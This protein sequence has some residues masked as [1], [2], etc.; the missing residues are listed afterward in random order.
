MDDLPKRPS[1]V[2]AGSDKKPRIYTIG[3][4]TLPF[5]PFVSLLKEFGI[6]LVADV[7]RFPSSRKF[8]HFNRPVLRE[9]L[10][11]EGIDYLWLE[12][13]GGRRHSDKRQAS[14]NTALKSLGFRNYADYMA[15]EEFR[16][17]V[18]KLL[19]VAVIHRTAIMCAE[20][21]YWKCHRRI[22][23]DYLTA[24]GVEVVHVLDTG[25]SS[26]HTLTPDAVVIKTGITYPPPK[27]GEAQ[28]SL[29]DLDV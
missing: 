4:S 6:D 11:A 24:Q 23:S 21:L 26:I 20:K 7:R 17:A 14:A 16:S 27:S 19:S 1:P 2:N 13:L 9:R 22:L 28:K 8:P 3:H 10:A 25:K 18:Q 29:F 15:M 12:A 5:E